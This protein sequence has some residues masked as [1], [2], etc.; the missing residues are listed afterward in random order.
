MQIID[1]ASINSTEM[2]FY[3]EFSS[4]MDLEFQPSILRHSVIFYRAD[5]LDK[6]TGVYYEVAVSKQVFYNHKAA[7]HF[8]FIKRQGKNIVIAIYFKE[9]DFFFLVNYDENL[10]Y[11]K[12]YFNALVFYKDYSRNYGELFPVYHYIPTPKKTKPKK[13]LVKSKP[14][15]RR[16]FTEEEIT[17][18]NVFQK[19]SDSL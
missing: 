9:R 8:D 6:N 10:R 17:I 7:G 15:E 18:R 14:V 11:E 16:E 13:L 4:V 12:S 3:T 5:F 1:A 2:R 19:L